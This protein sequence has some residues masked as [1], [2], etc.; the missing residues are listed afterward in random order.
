MILKHEKQMTTNYWI[1]FIEE[2]SH[3]RLQNSIYSITYEIFNTF[4][5]LIKCDERTLGLN[6]SI[7]TSK[8]RKLFTGVKMMP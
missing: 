7:S 1:D 2:M 3:R 4:Q 5:Q 8:H 6:M